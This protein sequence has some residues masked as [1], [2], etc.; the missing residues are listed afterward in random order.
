M[1]TNGSNN[2]SHWTE[3]I[4]NQRVLLF[5]F[6]IKFLDV[7][8]VVNQIGPGIVWLRFFTPFGQ[9][10]VCE[11]TTPFGP[12]TQRVYH[13]MY[14]ARTIPRW[15][16][17]SI[18]YELAQF[19]EQDVMIWQW[20]T[21]PSKPILNKEDASIQRFRKWYSQFYSTHSTLFDEAVQVYSKGR[22]AVPLD[23]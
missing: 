4:L 6:P 20:K 22:A 5:G 8:V 1:D 13:T 11:S 7:R 19:Y 12:M 15:M 16:A 21:F 18:L 9:L 10:L 17:K 23:W 14:A 2:L 3:I